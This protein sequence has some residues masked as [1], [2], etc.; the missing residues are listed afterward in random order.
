M[1]YPLANL[2]P[3]LN[4]QWLFSRGGDI[5]LYLGIV[6]ERRKSRQSLAHQTQLPESNVNGNV[7]EWD[8]G[9]TAT[10]LAF[11]T[12][13]L[14]W[15]E[16]YCYTHQSVTETTTKEASQQGKK[17]FG[18]ERRILMGKWTRSLLASLNFKRIHSSFSSPLKLQRTKSQKRKNICFAPHYRSWK[19][20]CSPPSLGLISKELESQGKH[21]FSSLFLFQ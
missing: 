16:F 9:V 12:W 17:Y 14:G 13:Y 15:K 5:I 21:T 4:L 19:Q 6:G 1:I 7:I 10:A 3:T 18:R 11:Q 2:T 8:H 20:Q